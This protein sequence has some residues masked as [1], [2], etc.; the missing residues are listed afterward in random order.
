[1]D[2]NV[3][4]KRSARNVS[5]KR[6]RGRQQKRQNLTVLIAELDAS[7]IDLTDKAAKLK[8][9]MRQETGRIETRAAELGVEL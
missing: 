2:A 3:K 6:S 7:Y 4:P 9:F 8:K 5:A 1:M